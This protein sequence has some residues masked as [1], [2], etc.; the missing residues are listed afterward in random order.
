VE[1]IPDLPEDLKPG[2]RPSETS[3]DKP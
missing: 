3:P 1:D 2:A